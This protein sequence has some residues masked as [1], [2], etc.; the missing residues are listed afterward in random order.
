MATPELVITATLSTSPTSRAGELQALQSLI[1]Q[2]VAAARGGGGAT[3]S[4]TL[5]GGAISNGSVSWT[6]TPNATS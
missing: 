5:S 2:A 3:T 4:G 6:Y 1:E